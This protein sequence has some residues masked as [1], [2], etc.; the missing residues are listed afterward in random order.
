MRAANVA[1]ELGKDDRFYGGIERVLHMVRIV[2]AVYIDGLLARRGHGIDNAMNAT[3]I[4]ANV[5]L[6]WVH[7]KLP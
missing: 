1:T 2:S 6:K 3:C 7:V 4:S 5:E